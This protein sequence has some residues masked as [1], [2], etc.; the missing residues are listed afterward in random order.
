MTLLVLT[1][2]MRNGSAGLGMAYLLV[3]GI[4]S[5][6]GMLIMSCIIGVPF[7]LCLKV[8]ERLPVMLQLSTASASIVFGFFYAWR[9]LS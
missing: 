5:I 1:E 4:G 3:F 8:S 9:T 7:V 6:G 2:V